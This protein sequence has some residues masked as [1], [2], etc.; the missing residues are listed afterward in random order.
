MH[1][2]KNS[3]SV[4]AGEMIIT[5][6]KPSQPRIG[7]ASPPPTAHRDAG[8]TL[9][10]VFDFCL[11]N[12]S[13]SFTNE[14]LLNRLVVELWNRQALGCL[15]LDRREFAERLTERKWAYDARRHVWKKSD[16]PPPAVRVPMLFE[17]N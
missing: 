14:A 8:S 4:I 3:A 2:K 13:E 17:T 9:S 15:A 10:D 11:A 6:Y 16:A 12:E 1:K 7:A 5:F